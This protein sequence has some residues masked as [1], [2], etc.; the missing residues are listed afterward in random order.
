MPFRPSQFLRTPKRWLAPLPG[1]VPGT[2]RG[3]ALILLGELVEG[4]SE[5]LREGRW[6]TD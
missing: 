1:K 3:L 6:Q 5:I 4:E 2:F